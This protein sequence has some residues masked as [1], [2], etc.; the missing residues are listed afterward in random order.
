MEK[1]KRKLHVFPEIT[2]EEEQENRKYQEKVNKATKK[3][4]EEIEENEI[5]KNIKVD[6]ELTDDTCFRLVTSETVNQQYLDKYPDLSHKEAAAFYVCHKGLDNILKH[7]SFKKRIEYQFNTG[8]IYKFTKFNN[9]KTSNLDQL[10]KEM[11]D[12]LRE[13][14]T[15]DDR[16]QIGVFNHELVKKCSLAEAKELLVQYCIR[17]GMS[18]LFEALCIWDD[19][20]YKKY[21]QELRK[22]REVGC[23]R[24]ERFHA[25][26][27]KY[28]NEYGIDSEED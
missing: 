4:E 16:Q 6:E 12:F 5:K 9:V 17:I 3:M 18:I 11:H 22:L 26:N 19:D 13:A 14:T 8:W 10:Y 20:I 23:G 15:E 25:F 27:K 7:K 28:D 21:E 1:P 24:R 2:L